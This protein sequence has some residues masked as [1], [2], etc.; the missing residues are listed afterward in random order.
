MATLATDPVEDTVATMA[1][2][3]VEAAGAT[4]ATDQ[5]EEVLAISAPVCVYA[6]HLCPAAHQCVQDQEAL[7]ATKSVG[8]PGP[9]R[10]RMNEQSGRVLPT[11]LR[12]KHPR[13]PSL[14]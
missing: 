9:A 12:R 7:V 14:Q 10:G 1:T 13:P 6:Y 3:L 8:G 2:N 5:V 11:R 4:E